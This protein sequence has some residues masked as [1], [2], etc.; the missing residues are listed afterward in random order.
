MNHEEVGTWLG[1]GVA[2][3]VAVALI[4]RSF[5]AQKKR[6]API[7]RVDRELAKQR[8]SRPPR[9]QHH[10]FAHQ[11]LRDELL[12][13]PSGAFRRITEP[14]SS[15]LLARLWVECPSEAD[16]PIPIEGLRTTIDEGIAVVTLPPPARTHEVYMVAVTQDDRYFVL[17]R[18]EDRAFLA[19]WARGRRIQHGE[20]P[21]PSI[22]EMVV[23]VRGVVGETSSAVAT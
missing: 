13:A 15:E 17:E 21:S 5:N 18:G 16:D 20:V 9:A 7:V 11:R 10:A 12:S 22:R 3:V 2:I 14:D 23:A 1:I 19:E 6:N 8:A 4:L